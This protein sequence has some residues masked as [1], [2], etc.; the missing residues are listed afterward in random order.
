MPNIPVPHAERRR[1]KC[2][3]LVFKNLAFEFS[4]STVC[5]SCNKLY[6]DYVVNG[7]TIYHGD[8]GQTHVK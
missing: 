7:G 6:M 2:L 1:I 8:V 3:G 4:A 5:Y